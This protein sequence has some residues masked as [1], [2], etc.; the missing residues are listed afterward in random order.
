MLEETNL[1]GTHRLTLKSSSALNPN[2]VGNI[3]Y[4]HRNKK[5]FVILLADQQR[6]IAVVNDLHRFGENFTNSNKLENI[7]GEPLSSLEEF[8]SRTLEI[9]SHFD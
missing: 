9:A 7:V 3:A 5:Y 6:F 1:E 4:D 8:V 2:Y